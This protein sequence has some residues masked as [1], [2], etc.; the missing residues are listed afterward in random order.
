MFLESRGG[1]MRA[2]PTGTV[3]FLFTDIEDSTKI[4]RRHHENWERLRARH[5]AILRTAIKANR[6]YVFNVVGD[7]FCAAFYTMGDAVG[8]AIRSQVQL[9]AELWG[10]LAVRVRMAIHS[11]AAEIQETGDY[12]GYLTLSRVQRLV[13]AG[14]GGQILLS[15]PAYELIRD[16]LPERVS[17]LDL[18]ERQLRGTIRAERIYQLSISGLPDHFAPLKTL[19]VGRN[20]LPTQMTGFVGREKEIAGIKEA[21]R[22][23]RLV[24]LTGPGGSGKTRLAL[25]VAAELRDEFT[26]GVWFVALAPLQTAEAILPTIASALGLPLYGSGDPL[27]QLLHYLSE[28][29]M[30]LILD[31]FENLLSGVNLVRDILT[32]AP[33]VRILSTSRT[34]LN[35]QGEQLYPLKGMDIPDLKTAT[36]AWEYGAI[37]LF[38]QGARRIDPDFEL[39]PESL[40]H[41][42]GICALV[43][44][45]PLGI[46]LASAWAR[47][48]TPQGILAEIERS[49]DF[50]VAEER[51][52]PDRQR[53]L[54]AVF[55]HTWHLLT[56]LEQAAFQSLAVFRGG[57]TRDAAEQVAAAS[58]AQLKNLA[59]KWLLHYDLDG[60]YEIHGLLRQYAQE[61]LD[62]ARRANELQQRHAEYFLQ[63]AERAEPELRGPKQEAWSAVLRHEYDNLRAALAWSLKHTD[64]SLVLRLAGALAEFWWYNGP[65]SEADE[66]FSQALERLPEAPLSVRAKAL[67]GAGMIAF[68]HASS[69]DRGERLIRDALAIGR[70]LEDKSILAWSLDLLSLYCTSDQA[71][72]RQGI[73][74]AEEALSLYRELDNPA[75]LAWVYNSLGELTRLAK[76]YE[77]A[78]IYYAHSLEK[79]RQIGDQTREGV[80]L[81]NLAFCAQHRGDYRQAERHAQDALTLFRR[82]GLR[83]QSGEAVAALAGPA[84]ALGDPI[85]AAT[86]FGASQAILDGISAAQQPADVDEFNGYLTLTHA[87]LSQQA[88]DTAWE[89]GRRLTYD[90][91]VALALRPTTPEE[92]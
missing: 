19:E 39:P 85:R 24:T 23:H 72:Y 32:T 88:F 67:T 68:A 89:C 8:A 86:L 41:V 17:A 44:G 3:V 13:S 21:I 26:D 78:G 81:G 34:R 77:R 42:A 46:L 62:E 75:G 10:E 79:A 5:D 15:A 74:F 28:R 38:M 52:L 11:G 48:L 63:L 66:W 70:Q 59:D 37:Q 6:G 73:E 30:L 92:N 14:H 57:F 80:A 31:N 83:G 91:A 35:V 84:A 61:R 87:G 22:E 18:G 76:D 20:N 36:D 53:S 4:A 69:T 9:Q 40:N 33:Q 58:L 51:D 65:V 71:R 49:L 12:H 90:Q 55:D 16:E 47:T 56:P 25:Q 54:R 45:L 50:L 29:M 1:I 64:A 7:A 2:L 82:L 60:R 43:E 27:P